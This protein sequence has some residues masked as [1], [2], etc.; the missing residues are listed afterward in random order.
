MAIDKSG[1]WWTGS[2][3][4]VIERFLIDLAAEEGTIPIRRYRAVACDCGGDAFRL[5]GD[6]EEGCARRTCVACKSSRFI[7][8]SGDY[9]SEAEPEDLVCHGCGADV[10]NVGVGFS[11]SKGPAPDVQ[12]VTVGQRCIGCG[13]LGSFVDW[14]ISYSPSIHLIDQV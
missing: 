3:A 4:A 12:W 1:E 11:I 13:V 8:D 9:W 14:K 6:D 2:Q 10:F 5:S 7:C